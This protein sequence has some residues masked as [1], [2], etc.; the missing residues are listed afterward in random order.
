MG[1]GGGDDAGQFGEPCLDLAVLYWLEHRGVRQLA[2][3]LHTVALSISHDRADDEDGARVDQSTM[4][5]NV[6]AVSLSQALIPP[7]LLGRVGS[8]YRLIAWGTMPLGALLL[9]WVADEYGSASAFTIGGAITAC[10]AARLT[11]SLGSDDQARSSARP[12]ATS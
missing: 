10:V 12:T 11:R 1:G 7:E 2:G 5:W 6:V 8:V 9:G 3:H 4:L